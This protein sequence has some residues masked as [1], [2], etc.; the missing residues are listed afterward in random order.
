MPFPAAAAHNCETPY[1]GTLLLAF[2]HINTSSLVLVLSTLLPACLLPVP[3][4]LRV[5]AA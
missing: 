1:C 5:H 3:V 4:L 2:I